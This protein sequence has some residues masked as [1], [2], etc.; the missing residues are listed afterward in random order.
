MAQRS[1]IRR[2][3]VILV[4]L[5]AVGIGGYFAW[6]W[7]TRLPPYGS[8][9]YVK[10]VQA[11][12]VGVVAL[13]L[14]A[15]D[16]GMNQTQKMDKEI[17]DLAPERLTEAINTIPQEPAAWADRGLWHLRKSQLAEAGRDLQQADKL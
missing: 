9:K 4:F 7:Y 12:Q 14:E 11:F 17:L 16:E 13:D 15:G 5:L 3:F 1:L 10:Y 2:P 8:A 6:K